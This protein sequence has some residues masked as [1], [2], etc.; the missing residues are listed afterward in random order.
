MHLN[1]VFAK[2]ATKR[3][4][5]E[6]TQ[7][8]IIMP[9]AAYNSAYNA[10]F[11]SA[12]TQAFVQLGDFTKT[13]TPIGAAA[14]VNVR[15]EPKASHDEMGGVYDTEYGRMSGML[16]LELPDPRFHRPVVYGLRLC[17]SAR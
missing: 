4:V 16:G 3:G 13:F 9:Q 10:N 11:P 12:P 7:D 2:T 17:Q 6:V 5:F 8:P 15:I 1:G 14:P